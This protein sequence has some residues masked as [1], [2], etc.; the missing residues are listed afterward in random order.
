MKSVG[1]LPLSSVSAGWSLWCLRS[2]VVTYPC[3]PMSLEPCLPRLAEDLPRFIYTLSLLKSQHAGIV[4]TKP[5]RANK[6]NQTSLFKKVLEDSPVPLGKD[7]TWTE[8]KNMKTFRY[9]GSQSTAQR[10]S[11]LCSLPGVHEL[12]LS[13]DGFVRAI[14]KNDVPSSSWGPAEQRWDKKYANAGCQQG[15]RNT[16]WT[17]SDGGSDPNSYQQ[18]HWTHGWQ[19][20]HGQNCIQTFP[21]WQFFPLL[22]FMGQS[23]RF[24]SI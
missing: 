24:F 1:G 8:L 23:P 2:D 12:L 9:G 18:N 20:Q 15:M 16:S 3:P 11:L 6:K 14:S 17:P 4:K 21:S 22:F 19:S 5:E 7:C 10:M 13:T